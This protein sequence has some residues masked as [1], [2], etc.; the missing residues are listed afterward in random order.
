MAKHNPDT[1][2]VL[3]IRLVATLIG[4]FIAFLIVFA[5][6]TLYGKQLESLPHALNALI[7]TGIMVPFMG[8]VVMPRVGAVVARHINGK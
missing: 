1:K 3:I 4:W 5:L 6:L 7:F 2:N 8:I